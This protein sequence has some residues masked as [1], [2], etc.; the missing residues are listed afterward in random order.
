MY[1]LPG[2]AY[3][4]SVRRDNRVRWTAGC[5]SIYEMNGHQ[6]NPL[7][8]DTQGYRQKQIPVGDDS[9]KGN[10]KG[11]CKDKSGSFALLRMTILCE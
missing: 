7:Q 4:S 2:A 8:E 6:Q 1:S 5:A 11:K 3:R 10:S 9:K